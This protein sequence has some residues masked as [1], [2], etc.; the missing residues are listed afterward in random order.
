MISPELISAIRSQYR[1]SW[2]GLHGCGHWARV[3]ENGLR[4]AAETG[5]NP[6]V[7]ELFAVFHDAC[8]INDD[9]DP[10]HGGRGAD[11]AVAFRGKY[12][13]LG[14]TD[15]IALKYAC[16]LHTDGMTTGDITAL[17]CWDADRLDLGRVG[18]MPYKDLLCTAAAKRPQLFEWANNRAFNRVIPEFAMKN[19]THMVMTAS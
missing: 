8:R 19:W 4:L 15:F 13:E 17:T 7:V 16:R 1:L 12:F 18:M 11:L 5:A 3:L 10:N 14:D 6:Q 9:W 2:N